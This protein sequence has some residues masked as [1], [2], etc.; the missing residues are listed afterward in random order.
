MVKDVDV[1]NPHS[2]SDFLPETSRKADCALVAVF[3]TSGSRNCNRV[4]I[5]MLV[6]AS[7]VFFVLSVRTDDLQSHFRDPTPF[8]QTY[9]CDSQ[10]SFEPEIFVRLKKFW[11]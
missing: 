1:E 7:S 8:S 10:H 5:H 9:C 2:P 11:E 3:V 4:I 6:L